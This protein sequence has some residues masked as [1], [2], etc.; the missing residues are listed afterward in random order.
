MV[1]FDRVD[2]IELLTIRWDRIMYQRNNHNYKMLLNVCKLIIDGMLISTDEGTLKL[3]N[4]LDDSYMHR[5]YE[6]FILEYYRYHHPELNANPD[7]VKWNLDEDN[8]MWLPKMITDV[9][10]KSRDGRVLIIDAK[11]YGK[12]MQS[13]YDTATYRNNN[14]YQ[15]FA[16]V[17]NWDKNKTGKVSGMLLYAK[18]SEE[19]QPSN[20]FMMDGNKISIQNINLNFPFENIS[21]QLE[22]IVSEYF[23]PL[24]VMN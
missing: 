5:L 12:Q 2:D 3:A 4:F 9:T 6:K 1:F 10:L 8:D 19:Y 13:N 17:K 18:T 22:K 11:Y 7:R 16:Y 24:V 23:S 21:E 15:I 14:L 20:Q